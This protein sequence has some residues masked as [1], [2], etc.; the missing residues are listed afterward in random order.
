[1]LLLDLSPLVAVVKLVC[2][3]QR[4]CLC[5][6]SEST[7]VECCVVECPA[8]VVCSLVVELQHFAQLCQVHE[9]SPFAF[10]IG[11]W[12]AHGL[13]VL[14][15]GESGTQLS[16]GCISHRLHTLF[17]MLGTMIS[18]LDHEDFHNFHICRL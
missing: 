17:H 12:V 15:F 4:H 5:T 16:S 8:C 14:L 11:L 10:A 2:H 18:E 13:A 7:V 6:R 1:V 3:S 9:C